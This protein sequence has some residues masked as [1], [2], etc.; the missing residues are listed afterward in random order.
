[1]TMQQSMPARIRPSGWWYLL[2]PVILVVAGGSVALLIF[3]GV[4]A[5]Q[6]MK[7]FVVPG[8]H[9]ITLAEAGKYIIYHEFRSV[10]DG[11]VYNVPTEGIS[12]LT[13]HLVNKASGEPVVLDSSSVSE[14]Y[15]YHSREG[16]SVF[17][18][19]IDEPGQYILA[20]TYP[21]EEEGPATVLTI[22]RGVIGKIVT[23]VFGSLGIIGA[24]FVL[25]LVVFLL[26]LLKRSA[27]KKQ[28]ARATP[29]PTPATPPPPPTAG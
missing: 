15:T 29:S 14:T 22:G 4:S 3:H 16:K 10:Q 28:L 9:E 1:M 18:F 7:S 20:A 2:V 19:Q 27:A 6:S 25:S 17:S 26:V 12:D 24:G 8:E 13:I 5:L 23:M 21:P 11:T